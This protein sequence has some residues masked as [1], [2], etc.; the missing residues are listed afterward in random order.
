MGVHLLLRGLKLIIF[1]FSCR[2]HWGLVHWLHAKLSLV[3]KR[4]Q[5]SV[6]PLDYL[7]HGLVEKV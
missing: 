3:N 6:F 2:V 5:L 7:C 1:H 4:E